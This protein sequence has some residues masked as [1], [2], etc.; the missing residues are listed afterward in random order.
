MATQPADA[1]QQ[2]PLFYRSVSLLSPQLQPGWGFEPPQNFAF[3]RNTH[4]IPLTVDEF[5]IAQRHYPVVFGSGQ[6]AAPLAL[7][8]MADGRN[9]FVDDEGNWTQGVYIPAYVRRYPFILAKQNPEAQDLSL[10]FDEESGMFGPDRGQPLFDGE[11]PSEA[12]KNALEFCSQFEQAVNRT[13]QFMA[14][15]EA[16]D[17]VID[18]E[19]TLQVA[20]RDQ[21]A[22]YRGFRMVDENKIRDLRGDQARK[23]V[24]NGVLG[25]VFAHLFSLGQ[26]KELFELA[27]RLNGEG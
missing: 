20:G 1:Q 9:L 27:A 4:A 21:P 17:L 16:L 6:G 14:E 22:V 12:T 25:I 5:V 2:L 8:G 23:L 18:G 7:V 26:I 11:D 24:S 3:A 15:I 19:V 10:C 13:R